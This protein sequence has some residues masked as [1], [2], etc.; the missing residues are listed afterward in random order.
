MGNESTS[1]Q[2]AEEFIESTE[3]EI[4]KVRKCIIKKYRRYCIDGR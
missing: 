3:R 2:N 4:E 1:P